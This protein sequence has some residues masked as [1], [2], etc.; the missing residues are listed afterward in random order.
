MSHKKKRAGGDGWL[1]SEVEVYW[2]TTKNWE[3]GRIV[4]YHPIRDEY[5]VRLFNALENR[6]AL[7]PR[8]CCSCDY[9]DNL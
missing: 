7:R 2:E 1:G 4:A 5:K 9:Y 3:K 6:P 8:P